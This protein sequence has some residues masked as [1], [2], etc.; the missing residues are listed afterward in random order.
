MT[1]AHRHV[2]DCNRS[3]F[4]TRTSDDHQGP[5]RGRTQALKQVYCPSDVYVHSLSWFEQRYCWITLG[6]E[7]ENAIWSE[8]GYKLRQMCRVSN[9]ATFKVRACPASFRLSVI[10]SEHRT[11]S[12]DAVLSKKLADEA[13]S[14]RNQDSHNAVLLLR[15]CERHDSTT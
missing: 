13:R 10:D 4:S 1:L 3:I 7:M 5:R 12:F 15:A 14:P 2:L 6:G 11:P 8:R 9:I